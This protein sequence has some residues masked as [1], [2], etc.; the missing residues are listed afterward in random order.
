MGTVPAPR[1]GVL[2]L[3]LWVEPGTTEMRA[4]ITEVDDIASGVE[5]QHTASDLGEVCA[6]AR[7]FVERF[8][9][10]DA[11]PRA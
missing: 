5:V 8:V 9:R 2:I 6:T 4:R 11:D 1:T 7:R 10:G 3:R